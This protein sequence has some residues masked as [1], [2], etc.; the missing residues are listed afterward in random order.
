MQAAVNQRFRKA[1][2][3]GDEGEELGLGEK[4]G[5]AFGNTFAAAA[6]DKPVMNDSDAHSWK[7]DFQYAP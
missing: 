5:N 1:A 6:S 4:R 7:P 3:A 2:G